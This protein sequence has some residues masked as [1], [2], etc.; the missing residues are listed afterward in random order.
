MPDSTNDTSR[1]AMKTAQI[2]VLV[3]MAFLP[4]PD[5]ALGPP[6]PKPEARNPKEGRNPKPE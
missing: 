3:V 6:N 5:P 4:K 1:H 2:K